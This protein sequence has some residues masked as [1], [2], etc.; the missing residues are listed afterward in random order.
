MR[1]A[2]T[3]AL[4]AL[5]ALTMLV[6]AATIMPASTLAA[7]YTG[8]N[9]V[10]FSQT[11]QY[12]SLGFLTSWLDNGGL[13]TIGYPITGEFQQDQPGNGT[14][15][16]V[17][18]F[19][20]AVFEYHADAPE[21]QGVQLRRLGADLAA[22]ASARW[23]A[24]QSKARE[25]ASAL[26]FPLP[27]ASNPFAPA[28]T[29]ED[30]A[31]S[32]YFSATQHTLSNGFYDFWGM[33]GGV[34]VFG[35]PISEEF[36]DP[37]TGFTVQYFERA[38]FEWHPDDP[39]GQTVQLRLLGTDAARRDGVDANS[40]AVSD[41]TPNYSPG[42]WT[43]NQPSD[44]AALTTPLPGAPS[45]FPKWIE[46]NLSQQYMRAWQN[47]KVV[48]QEYISSGLPPNVTPPGYFKIFYK[49]PSDEMKNGK[50][51]DPDYYDLKNV[52]WV[53]YFLAGGYALHG[54]YW[55]TN[56]GHEMSHGCV[57][58]STPGAAWLYQWAPDGTTVW[59]H[60]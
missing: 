55:H 18:Y 25:V 1:R 47:N 2:V 56:F 60:N 9:R 21:G 35:Y 11:G 45:G 12:L 37:T 29:V 26:G 41:G 40:V 58:M 7:D 27:D 59:I 44:P 28:P 6:P 19:E 49:L 51:G 22:Q 33:H 23:D 20:R 8:P 48:Y 13:T 36:R 57:N 39:N 3:L 50:P 42:L 14:P 38:I 17:Q 52:P 34:S 43:V 4:G 46:V 31:S 32:V 5:L 24:G 54:T 30:D 10:Y 53:M 15:V 16:T